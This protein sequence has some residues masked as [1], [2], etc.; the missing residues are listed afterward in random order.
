MPEPQSPIPSAK[1]S[2]PVMGALM[3]CGLVLLL[4]IPIFLIR[5]IISERVETRGQALTEVTALWGGPQSIVG[6]RLVV[7]FRTRPEVQSSD[8]D[9]EPGGSIAYASFLPTSLSVQGDLTTE[10]TRGLRA[11]GVRHAGRCGRG[12]DVGASGARH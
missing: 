10:S 5:G 7:P 8:P 12:R 9:S 2:R 4:Q 3:I 6:P 1:V 11:A